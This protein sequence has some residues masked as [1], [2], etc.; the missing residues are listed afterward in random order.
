VLK[1]NTNSEKRSV[2]ILNKAKD[3][4]FGILLFVLILSLKWFKFLNNT[5]KNPDPH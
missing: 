5:I 1:L 4:L 3:V 2:S